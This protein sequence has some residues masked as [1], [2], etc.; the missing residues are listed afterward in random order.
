MTDAASQT[1]KPINVYMNFNYA[2]LRCQGLLC[3]PQSQDIPS[4]ETFLKMDFKG[5]RV[6]LLTDMEEPREP[7]IAPLTGSLPQPSYHWF[8]LSYTFHICKCCHVPGSACPCEIQRKEMSQ[9]TST[10]RTAPVLLLNPRAL[11]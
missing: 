10:D 3:S 4:R 6:H 2:D 7:K 5:R 8:A 1:L 11:V 9:I